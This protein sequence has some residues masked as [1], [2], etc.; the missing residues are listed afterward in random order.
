[1]DGQGRANPDLTGG[2]FN[3]TG[4]AVVWYNMY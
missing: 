2:R 1:M 4:W 3:L